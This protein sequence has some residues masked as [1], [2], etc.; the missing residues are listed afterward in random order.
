M[1]AMMWLTMLGN[2]YIHNRR[3]IFNVSNSF[4]LSIRSIVSELIEGS[5]PSSITK[6]SVFERAKVAKNHVP[7]PNNSVFLPIVSQMKP[8]IG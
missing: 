4:V 3:L 5:P 1:D 8:K 7:N 2:A 6:I